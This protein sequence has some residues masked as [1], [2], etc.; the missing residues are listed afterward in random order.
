VG[1]PVE[2]VAQADLRA[3]LPVAATDL[4]AAFFG[5]A[6]FADF[7]AAAFFAA[8]LVAGAFFV[9]GSPSAVGASAA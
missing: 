2:A 4:P 5:G 8:A 6:F 3:L 9:A 7:F 1:V